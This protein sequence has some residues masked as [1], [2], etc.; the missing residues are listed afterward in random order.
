MIRIIFDLN[1]RHQG[2]GGAFKGGD[3]KAIG[4]SF[5]DHFAH[6]TFNCMP[7]VFW[8]C[9]SIWC[10]LP[11]LRTIFLIVFCWKMD[12]WPN[13]VCL[14]V[15]SYFLFLNFW[16]TFVNMNWWIIYLEL[17]FLDNI[18]STQIGASFVFWNLDFWNIFFRTNWWI[19]V[20]LCTCTTYYFYSPLDHFSCYR[21]GGSHVCAWIVR[22]IVDQFA[23]QWGMAGF[24][25]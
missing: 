1:T 21:I 7:M 24:M 2:G 14:C 5:S 9:G 22:E 8:T 15:P 4:G 3:P 18:F 6:C 13:F 20:V 19:N 10:D 23:W 25:G 16:I 17:T 11:Q 12:C